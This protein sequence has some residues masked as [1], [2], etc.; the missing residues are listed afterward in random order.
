MT[1]GKIVN[2]LFLLVGTAFIIAG[3]ISGE[4]VLAV[5]GD[6]LVVIGVLLFFLYVRERPVAA[7]SAGNPA[8]QS[9]DPSPIEDQPPQDPPA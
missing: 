7:P 9:T 1:I 3:V 2:V 5:P 4:W 8:A 6:I